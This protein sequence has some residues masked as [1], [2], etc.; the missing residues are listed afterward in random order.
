MQ[1]LQMHLRTEVYVISLT[2]D[3][4]QFVYIGKGLVESRPPRLIEL[5][6]IIWDIFNQQ[7]KCLGILEMIFSITW[8]LG[9]KPE[10]LREKENLKL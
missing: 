3:T 8:K 5:L 7:A 9:G 10:S 2:T 1:P 6:L 4:I